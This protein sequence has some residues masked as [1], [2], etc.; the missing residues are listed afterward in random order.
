MQERFNEWIWELSST[1]QQLW[2]YAADTDRF[3][4]DT[5]LPPVVPAEH[6]DPLI[7]ARRLLKFKIPLINIIWEE[8]PFEW[9]YPHQFGV[10]RNYRN[11]PLAQMRVLANFDPLPQGGTRLSYKT[12]VKPRNILGRLGWPLVATFS[13]WQFGK[14]FKQYD[15]MAQ[16]EAATQAA[17]PAPPPSTQL[18][19]GGS[20]RIG[21]IGATLHTMGYPAALINR[22]NNT[23]V[24]GDPFDLS[25]MRPY[26][27][28]DRWQADRREILDLFMHA[29]RQG[30]LSLQ[31]DVMCPYCRGTKES[32]SHLAEIG[33]TV[34][35]ESCAIDFEVN[36]DRFVEISFAPNPSIRSIERLDYC[37]AGPE[38]TPHIVA[39][40]LLP[41]RE[42]RQIT[43]QFDPGRYRLRTIQQPGGQPLRVTADGKSEVDLVATPA[44]WLHAEIELSSNPALHLWNETEIE[45]LFVLERM[46]W[47]DDAVTAAEVTTRQH[48][49]DLFATE[50]L[51]PGDQI[52]VGSLAILFT[53]LKGSTSMYR[54]IGDA[55]A[56]GLVMDHFDILKAA[57]AAEQ[58]AIV[59][60]IGDAVMAVFQQPVSAVRAMRNAQAALSRPSGDSRPLVIKGALHYGPCIAVNLND[61]LDYFGSTVNMAARLEKFSKGNDI[62]VSEAVWN[63]PE[64]RRYIIEEEEA[65]APLQ[66]EALCEPL[67]GF[68]QDSFNLWR[69]SHP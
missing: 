11:G 38:V 31:W 34:H 49:R 48:F 9:S 33:Q 32:H 52:S 23:I 37:V 51:R 6:A 17:P 30:L 57:I 36:F 41:P 43:V 12:W 19:R 27:Y 65:N 54:E 24:K 50:A 13:Q 8:E 58:G 14:V 66:V 29:T 44:G 47:G 3:N 22:L 4:R 35:C 16:N 45:Q 26:S 40:Q 61:R 64:L 18:T 10:I 59:K 60:T 39:Q 2:P 55:P 42:S 5:L 63:D 53:D 68:E 46:A 20:G 21:Q 56:F 67:R 62:I 69:I 7:N 25:R 1:P 15:Q 28:A